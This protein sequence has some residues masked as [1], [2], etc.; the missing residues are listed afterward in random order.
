MR[1]P[2][3]QLPFFR[4][5]LDESSTRAGGYVPVD[6]SNLVAGEVFA[7][8]VEIHS[9]T[10]KD[11][12]IFT[13]HRVVYEAV[14]ADLNLPNVLQD[15]TCLVRVHGISFNIELKLTEPA[16]SPESSAQHRRR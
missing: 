11:G 12:V 6:G 15:F 3:G 7:D 8:L 14:G 2:C 9:A 16:A 5:F 1:L 4:E 10:A 13:G